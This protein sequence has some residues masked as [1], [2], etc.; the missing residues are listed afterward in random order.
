MALSHGVPGILSVVR[1]CT[2]TNTA[3][4]MQVCARLFHDDVSKLTLLR[5]LT[6]EHVRSFRSN[7]FLVVDSFLGSD[8]ATQLRRET[9]ALHERGALTT[10]DSA[11]GPVTRV[12]GPDMP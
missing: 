10:S 7:G 5:H 8:A 3:S 6:A 12:P 1:V 9:L 4:A 2:T 11:Q